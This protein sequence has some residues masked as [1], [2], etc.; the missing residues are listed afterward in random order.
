MVKQF[1]IAKSEIKLIFTA[2]TNRNREKLN[3][4]VNSVFANQECVRAYIIYICIYWERGMKQYILVCVISI[5]PHYARI[6]LLVSVKCVHEREITGQVRPLDWFVALLDLSLR[7]RPNCDI[8]ALDCSLSLH[9]TP[10]MCGETSQLCIHGRTRG[11][12]R[13]WERGR[14]DSQFA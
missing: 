4:L 6:R 5:E 8:S 11:K 3:N 9:I 7:L 10:P 12:E 2:S 13:V 1:T 14:R